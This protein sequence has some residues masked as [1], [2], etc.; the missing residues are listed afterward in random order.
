MYT[1][2]GVAKICMRIFSIDMGFERKD[3]SVSSRKDIQVMAGP[4]TSED[5]KMTKEIHP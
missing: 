4:A 2:V 5:R 3:L 1:A